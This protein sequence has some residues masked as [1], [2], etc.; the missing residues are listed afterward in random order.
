MSGLPGSS[1]ISPQETN[2]PFTVS[3]TAC[4]PFGKPITND[5]P[6]QAYLEGIGHPVDP[7]F[8]VAHSNTTWSYPLET[9]Y[10]DARTQVIYP[11]ELLAGARTITNLAL[12]VTKAPG[13]MTNWTIRMK[14]SALDAYPEENPQWESNDWIIVYQTNQTISET[15]WVDFEFT[16]PFEY[17]G[18]NNLMVDFSFNNEEYYTS[19]YCVADTASVSRAIVFRT[20]SE[21]DDPLT[22]GGTNPLR[23]SVPTSPASALV[24]RPYP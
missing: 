4:N 10:E 16:T 13:P 12:R 5:V 14:H 1:I 8:Y 2:R 9:Y 7:G 3:I 24:R 21:Y 23:K 19:G 22:W 17:N 18:T 11:A 6:D 20:D 15:G